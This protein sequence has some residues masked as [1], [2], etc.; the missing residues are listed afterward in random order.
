MSMGVG[1]AGFAIFCSKAVYSEGHDLR[2]LHST[3]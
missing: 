1:G 3:G 2:P